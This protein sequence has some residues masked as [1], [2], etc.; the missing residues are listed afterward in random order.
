MFMC[1]T[2][3]NETLLKCF[4]ES[5]PQSGL[6][7]KNKNAVAVMEPVTQTHLN[8]VSFVTELKA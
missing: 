6:K 7:I 1:T 3:K 8:L 2:N 5:F 4:Q